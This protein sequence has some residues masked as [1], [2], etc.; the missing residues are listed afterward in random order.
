MDEYLDIKRGDMVRTRNRH[1]NGVVTG[2]T[3]STLSGA[4]A[5]FVRRRDT[6]VSCTIL[7]QEVGVVWR[8][9]TLLKTAAA[10]KT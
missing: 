8:R 4:P 9:E 6:T 2:R 1:V 10:D 3:R 7:V 5:L